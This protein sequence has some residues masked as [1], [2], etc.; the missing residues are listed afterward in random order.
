[1]KIKSNIAVSDNGFIFNPATGDSFS[2]NT[3]G[4]EIVS[5]VK[6]GET[7]QQIKASIL[8]KYEV[9][10]EQ[11]DRDWEDWVMQLKDANLLEA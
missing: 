7:E 2:S 3:I 5:A 11:L 6:R 1:M 9:S 10:A 4:S 8:E